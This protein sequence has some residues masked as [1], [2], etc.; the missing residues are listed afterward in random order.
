MDAATAEEE[1]AVLELKR[2]MGLAYSDPISIEASE[3]EPEPIELSPEESVVE[4]VLA[5]SLELLRLQWAPEFS[6]LQARVQ[7]TN[8]QLLC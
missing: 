8:I 5:S 4:K 1:V 2:V 3:I 7:G 6:Q